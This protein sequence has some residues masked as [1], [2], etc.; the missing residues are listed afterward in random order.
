M[1]R[2]SLKLVYTSF[3]RSSQKLILFPV[4][5]AATSL[6]YSCFPTKHLICDPQRELDMSW[7]LLINDYLFHSY[8]NFDKNQSGNFIGSSVIL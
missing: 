5:L 3:L 1:W 4:G 6:G 8:K 2:Q 7:C